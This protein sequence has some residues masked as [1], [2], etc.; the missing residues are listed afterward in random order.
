MIYSLSGT[1]KAKTPEAAVIDCAGV[2]FYVNTPTSVYAELGE[3]GERGT[4]FT[5][6]NVKDDGVDLYGFADLDSQR[7]FR[8]LLGVSGVGPKVALAILSVYTPQKIA[9]AVAAGDHKAFS[10]VSGVG[11]KLAARLALELKDKVNAFGA[12]PESGES[13]SVGSD[14]AAD[15]VAALVALG[16]SHSEAL[17][18]V[19]KL[20]R[21][22]STEDMLRE[23]LRQFGA[24]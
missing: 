14:A 4:L 5:Y 7:C 21:Q 22:L 17:S 11:P 8:T 2:G 9:L 24:R 18:T 23:A 16:F 13:A 15:T 1:I 3:V 12:A 6:M 10:A 20:P 19:A